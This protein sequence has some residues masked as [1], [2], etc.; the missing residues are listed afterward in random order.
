[1]IDRFFGMSQHVITNPAFWRAMR[2]CEQNLY[3]YLMNQSERY[4]TRQLTR[5]DAQVTELVGAASR[6]LCNA[7]KRLQEKEL[8]NYVRTPGKSTFTRS[9][10]PLTG[11]PYPGHPKSPIK[12][13]KK[14]TSQSGTKPAGL[15]QPLRDK[16]SVL[17]ASALLRDTELGTEHHGVSLKF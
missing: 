5:S 1:M 8:I 9:A 14:P 11:K 10:D 13:V 4:S 3:V 2:P 17:P 16:N 12:Y 15:S 7:R 6:S